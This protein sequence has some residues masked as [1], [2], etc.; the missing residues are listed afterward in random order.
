MST[1]ETKFC[2]GHG[3][4]EEVHR[5]GQPGVWGAYCRECG[6]SRVRMGIKN[7]PNRIGRPPLKAGTLPMLASTANRLR[8][9]ADRLRA[10]ASEALS[11]YKKAERLARDAEIEIVE[12]LG[13]VVPDD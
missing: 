9:D 1:I 11:E 5:Q 8:R 13:G 12:K 7:S 10:R 3:C 2:A 4:D 6:R